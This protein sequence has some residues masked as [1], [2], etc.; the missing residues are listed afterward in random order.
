MSNNINA[1]LKKL[2]RSE[3][4]DIILHQNEEQGHSDEQLKKEIERIKSQENFSRVVKST[5]SA[6]ITI[7]AIAVLLSV[8]LFPVL[9]IYGNSMTPIL[10]DEDVVLS[11]KGSRFDTG[12]VVAFYYN[13]KILIKRVIAIAGDWVNIDKKGNVYINE[14]KID[15]PYVAELAF[16]NC[17]I[18][19]PFQVPDEK[20]FVMGDNRSVSIDSRNT[21]IGC[22]SDEQIVG[23]IIMRIWPLNRIG[24]L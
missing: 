24:K 6:L 22:V 20:I 19:L 2:R 4:L 18:E 15:E 10:S 8:L 14:K 13:N 12:D 23:K 11:V 16:G 1:D 9:R 7:A 17:D 3:L 21:A 5:I